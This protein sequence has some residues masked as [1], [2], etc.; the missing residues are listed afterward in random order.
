MRGL[1]LDVDPRMT[2]QAAGREAV[3]GEVLHDAGSPPESGWF[4]L[5]E[6]GYF[7]VDNASWC[8]HRDDDAPW[9]TE[10]FEMFGTVSAALARAEV[11]ERRAAD[12]EGEVKRLGE[13]VTR[14]KGIAG[15]LEAAQVEA[16]SLRID[17]KAERAERRRLEGLVTDRGAAVSQARGALADLRA[18]ID[19]LIGDTSQPQH[20]TRVWATDLRA[21]LDDT[22]HEQSRG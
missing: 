5:G 6:N 11:A 10:H 22:S 20:A 2:E 7:D 9:T 19:A 17:V 21:V 12:A 3:L 1:R 4:I 15:R 13:Y 8:G 18:R 16:E 14:V